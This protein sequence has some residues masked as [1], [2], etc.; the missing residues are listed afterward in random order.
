MKSVA[1]L[2]ISRED[3]KTLSTMCSAVESVCK[4]LRNTMWCVHTYICIFIWFLFML[5]V[6]L[7]NEQRSNIYCKGGVPR[8]KLID[9]P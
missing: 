4:C 1:S 6:S 7:N 5:G 8:L 9:A 3:E 2:Q